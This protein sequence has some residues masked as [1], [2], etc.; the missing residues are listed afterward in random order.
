MS[1]AQPALQPPPLIYAR[2]CHNGGATAAGLLPSDLATAAGGSCR[3]IAYTVRSK[4]AGMDA[5]ARREATLLLLLP[6][7]SML[8]PPERPLP[9]CRPICVA[10]P[11]HR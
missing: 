11:V 4:R 6:P 2:C 9:R 10:A 3:L 5:A 8:P 7:P 1:G